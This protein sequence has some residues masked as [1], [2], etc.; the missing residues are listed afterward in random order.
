[1]TTAVTSKKDVGMTATAMCGAGVSIGLKVTG[2][3]VTHRHRSSMNRL[4]RRASASF[5]HP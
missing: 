5:F 1:M 3:E 2:D 4:H